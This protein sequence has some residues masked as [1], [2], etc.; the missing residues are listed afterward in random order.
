MAYRIGWFSTGRDEAAR[1]L[2]NKIHKELK[3]GALSHA[4]I[5]FVFSNREKGEKEDSDKFLNLAKKLGLKVISFSSRKFKPA[6]RK[7][8]LEV[9][10]KLG[11]DS[12]TLIIWR[13]EYDME[14]IERLKGYEHQLDVL[15]GDMLIWGFRRCK[16]FNA[17]N[18]H[19]ALPN[20][21]KGTWQDVIWEIIRN[22]SAEH[23]VMIHLVT[24]ELDC[25]PVITYC[26]FS[27]QSPEFESLWQKLDKKLKS[28]SL[29]EIIKQEGE[30]LALFAKI[31]EKGFI[32][33]IPLLIHTIKL[34]ANGD[35]FL[36]DKRPFTKSRIIDEGYDLTDSI[37]AKIKK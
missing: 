16:V 37:D 29:D 7:R 30:K 14:V 18:L 6:L 10:K 20:G 8:G 19:P 25:G 17:I 34:F 28:K 32:R 35:I 12:S 26:R 13:N 2:L 33:E 11:R 27:L 21:P 15:A 36:R 24:P 3:E 22:R 23:G 4:E 5:S 1:I 9:S 31:R